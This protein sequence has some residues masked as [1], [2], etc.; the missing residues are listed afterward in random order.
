[1]KHIHELSELTRLNYVYAKRYST[2]ND[3]PYV[4]IHG[5]GNV[6]SVVP[7]RGFAVGQRVHIYHR[8][9]GYQGEYNV[10]VV[11]KFITTLGRM[12]PRNFEQA[13]EHAAQEV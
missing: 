1:M 12:K 4:T 7:Q 8:D 13:W 3:C 5:G 9:G 11:V 2:K 6:M 10:S